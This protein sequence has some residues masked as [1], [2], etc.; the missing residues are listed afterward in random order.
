MCDDGC[1]ETVE[2]PLVCAVTELRSAEYD[3]I[4]PVDVVCK[5]KATPVTVGMPC[6]DESE[7]CDVNVEGDSVVTEEDTLEKVDEVSVTR[8]E[9]C[10]TGRDVNDHYVV[11]IDD[12]LTSTPACVSCIVSSARSEEMKTTQVHPEPRLESILPLVEVS[13]RVDGCSGRRDEEVRRIQ[14]M[15]DLGPRRTR[16]RGSQ[17]VTAADKSEVV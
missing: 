15:A 12:V 10:V 13:D 17:D 16:S 14:E 11:R 1:G 4:L 2:M 6:S 3:V 9:V 8:V 7:V 5:L